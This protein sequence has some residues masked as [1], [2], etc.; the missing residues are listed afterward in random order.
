MSPVFELVDLEVDLNTMDETGLPWAF[1]DSAAGPCALEPGR[2]IVLGGGAVRALA[3]I[4]DIVGDVV[5][6]APLRGPVSEH[7]HLLKGRHAS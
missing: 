3:M 2:H 5:H 1:V 6:V 4:V 7:R